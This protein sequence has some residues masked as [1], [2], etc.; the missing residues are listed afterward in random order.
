LEKLERG[1]YVGRL[2]IALNVLQTNKYT[3][4]VLCFVDGAS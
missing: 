4:I 3:L 1:D 2:M